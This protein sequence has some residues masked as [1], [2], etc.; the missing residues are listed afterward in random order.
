MNTILTIILTLPILIIILTGAVALFVSAFTVI[1]IIYGAI[2]N[3]NERGKR[4]DI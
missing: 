4:K 1:A 2:S 3:R